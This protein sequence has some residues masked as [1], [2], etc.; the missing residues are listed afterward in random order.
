MDTLQSICLM[1][2]YASL[3]V[4]AIIIGRRFLAEPSQD[5]KIVILTLIK[6]N[7]E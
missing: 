1:Q 3:T 5:F 4:L 7:T 6:F 2:F